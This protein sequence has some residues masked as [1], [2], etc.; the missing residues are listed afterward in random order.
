MKSIIV[1]MSTIDILFFGIIIYVY[2]LYDIRYSFNVA[3]IDI[4]L[5]RWT[6]YCPN[7]D[8]GRVFG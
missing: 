6:N 3:S 1:I 8:R 7:V 5:V 4:T 2:V